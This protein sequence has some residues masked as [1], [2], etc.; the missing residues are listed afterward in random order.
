MKILSYLGLRLMKKYRIVLVCLTHTIPPTL[1]FSSIKLKETIRVKSHTNPFKSLSILVS[2]RSFT[3]KSNPTRDWKFTKKKGFGRVLKS[4]A[5]AQEKRKMAFQ[6]I[7]A[8]DGYIYTHRRQP[9]IKVSS[10]DQ[11]LPRK[12]KKACF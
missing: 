7:R 3:Q 11:G 9:L 1:R 6:L 5:I 10:N 2:H 12:L 4:Q 8:R